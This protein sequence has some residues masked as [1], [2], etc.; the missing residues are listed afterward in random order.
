MT[1]AYFYKSHAGLSPSGEE[2]AELLQKLRSGETV[3]VEVRRPRNVQ[4]HRKFF[5][6]LGF[7]YV[8]W[9]PEPVEYKGVKVGKNLDVFRSW[10]IARAGYYDLSITP[11]GKVRAEPKSMAFA[12]MD[13]LQFEKLFNDVANVVLKYVLTSYKKSDLDDV[14]DRLVRF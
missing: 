9:E 14:V 13:Q 12:N 10:C 7:A 4:Y 8:H 6:M 1:A 11:D 2:A 5:A 3:L